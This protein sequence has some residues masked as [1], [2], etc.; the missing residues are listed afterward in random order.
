[1]N[2]YIYIYIFIILKLIFII[3]IEQTIFSD[4]YIDI[5][6]LL[7]YP[8]LPSASAL[9]TLPNADNDKLIFAP[10]LNKAPEAPVFF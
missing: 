9:I 8:P 5:I 1:M 2:I 4:N 7:T 6:I 10:S 3:I